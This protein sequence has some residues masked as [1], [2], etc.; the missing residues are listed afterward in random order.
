MVFQPSIQQQAIF[1]AVSDRNGGSL[2]IEAVAGAGKTTTLVKA[3]ELMSGNIFLGAYNS[4]MAKELKERTGHLANVRA[5]TF[6]SA[7]FN[8]LRYAYKDR[9]GKDVNDKK[10][11]NIVDRFLGDGTLPANLADIATL[12][13]KTVSMA[14]QRGLGALTDIRDMDAWEAMLDQFGLTDDL[15]EWI[16]VSDYE[17]INASIRVL[18]KSNTILNPIDFDDMV[19]L[20]LVFKL[21]LFPQDWVLI[22]EAQDTNPTR[23]ALAARMLKPGGRVIAVGDRCQ[24]LGT[25][26]QV[27][28]GK[29]RWGSEELRTVNIEDLEIGDKVVSYDP[30]NVAFIRTGCEILGI[31]RRPF[32]GDLV[33]VTTSGNRVSKYTPNHIC[34]AS[35]T[36]LRDKYAV[37]VMRRGSQYRI[38]KAK[39]DYGQSGS[40]VST[41]MHSEGA[42]AAWILSLH[43]SEAEA[44]FQEQAVAG[45]FGLPQ[46]MFSAKDLLRG[47]AKEYLPRAWAYIGDNSSRGA[48]VL[49]AFGRDPTYPLFEKGTLHQQTVK[50]PRT[51]RACNLMDGVKVLPYSE[52]AHAK[53]NSWETATLAREAYNGDVVSLEVKGTHLYVADGIVTHNCQAIYGFTGADNDAMNQLQKQFSARELPLTVSYRCP[54]AVVA[55]ARNWVSHITAADTA[56]EGSFSTMNF[57][58]LNSTV[59]PGDMVL[60]RFNKYLVSTC[61]ALIRQGTPARIEGRAIGADLVALIT[62]WKITSI[63]TL[64]TRIEAWMLKEVKKALAKEDDQRAARIADRGETVKVLIE[65]ARELKMT[66]IAQL[67]EMTMSMFDDRVVDKKN[68]VTLCSVH[69][70]KGLENP[71]VFILGR[72]ELMGRSMRRQWQSEQEINL[73]YVAV[74]RAQEALIEVVGVA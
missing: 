30:G 59:K 35:F 73:I 5:G 39:M 65:R 33:V 47:P 31:T 13:A 56:P 23:R 37:Y 71:R 52:T 58:D 29:N 42:D 10:V 21:R 17:I 12:I 16:E 54:Q 45:R 69:R 25:Q 46:L 60:C 14:K 22:D 34:Y 36:D 50:R 70:S 27:P 4:K 74:T 61:F 3:L 20:P 6:H 63:D 53:K 48:D 66:T 68:M 51:I 1:D 32:R 55:H 72:G 8:A 15:P 67:A 26:V 19:Y 64:E 44:Y 57:A 7:G 24:P 9:L 43:D 38:G 49:R 40:G 62:K 11:I 28:V 2:I 18:E 41:R